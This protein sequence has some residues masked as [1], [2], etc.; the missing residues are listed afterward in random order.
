MNRFPLLWL[1]CLFVRLKY[2]YT[3]DPTDCETAGWK[4]HPHAECLQV[5]ANVTCVCL[6]GYQGNGQE[7]EDIDE[8]LSGLSDCHPNAL[9]NNTLGSYSCACRPGY[10]GNGFLCQ[11][12]NECQRENGRCHSNATCINYEGGSGCKCKTGFSGNGFQCTDNDEC[13]YQR[14]C[15]WNATCT[16][17]PG[18]Y[19]CTCNAGYKGNGNY[20][21]LDIDECSQTPVVCSSSLGYRGCKNLPGTYQCSCSTGYQN[22]GNYCQDIDECAAKRCSQYADCRNTLGSYRCTC[23]LGFEGNGLSCVDVNECNGN[24]NCHSSAVCINVVGRYECSC[25]PGFLGDGQNCQDV[26][27]CI[28]VGIC[29]TGAVCVNN[30]GSYDCNCGRGY[31]YNNSMCQDEDECASGLCSPYASCTNFP[32]SFNC[33]CKPGFNG[34]GLSCVDEDECSMARQCHANA[35]CINRPGSYNCSCE[36]GYSG[37]GVLRCTD[38]NECLV[39]NGGCRNLATCVNAQGSFSCLCSNGFTLVNKTLCQDV[40]ECEENSVACSANE[41]CLNTAGSYECRCLAGFYRPGGQVGCADVD[42]CRNKPCHANATCLNAEGSYECTCNG[43]FSGN[44]THCKDVNECLAEGRCH[45]RALC[46]N[47]EG[48]FSCVCQQGFVGDGFYCEDVNECL[49]NATCPPISTCINSPGAYVCSCLN[50]SVAIDSLCLLPSFQCDPACHPHGLCHSSPSGYQCVCDLGYMGDGLTCSDI[51]ECQL[52]NV[53]PRNETECVNIP[54]SFAC[55][56][57][58]GF[59]LNETNCVDVNECESP[60]RRCSE[61]SSCENTIGSHLCRCLSG[62]AGDGI[63]CLD[64]D[65]CQGDSGG[66]HPAASCANTPGSFRCTCQPGTEGSGFECRDVD[67]CSQNATLPHNCS[68]HGVCGNTDGSYRCWC[69]DGYH[70]DGFDC[71]DTDECRSGVSVCDSNMKCHNTLGSYTCTCVLGLAYEQGTCVSLNECQNASRSCHVN[72]RC[73]A[74]HSSFY[75]RCREGYFGDGTNCWDVDECDEGLAESPWDACPPSSSCINSNGS[76][77]CECWDGFRRAGKLCQDMD[78]CASGNFSCPYKST[79]HNVDGGYH[80]PCVP[81]FSLVNDSLCLDVDECSLGLDDC[82]HVSDC[83][84]TVGSFF[85]D[86]WPGYHGNGTVAWCMDI[87]EC[88]GNSTC[89]EHSTCNNTDGDFLCTCDSGFS[90]IDHLCVDVDECNTT[91]QAQPCANGVCMNTLGSYYCEC[92]KGYWSNETE[93]VDVDECSDLLDPSIDC[94]PF[95]TCVN[96]PGSYV[97]LCDEGFTLILTNSTSWIRTNE[98]IL[99]NLT[100]STKGSTL[101]SETHWTPRT[102]CQD[103]NECAGDPCP[104]YATC[105]NVEGSFL[106]LCDEGFLPDSLSYLS[107]NSSDNGSTMFMLHGCEDIDECVNH[108]ACRPDQACANLPGGYVCSCRVGYRE[109]KGACVDADECGS[110]HPC[111]P[112]ARCWNTEGSFSCHCLPGHRGN[113]TWCE[114]VDEC[115]ALSRPCHPMARCRN[116]LGSFWCQCEPGFAAL[117]TLCIDLD[118][119]LQTNGPCQP[120]ATCSNLVGGFDCQCKRGWDPTADMVNGRR[121]CLDQDEC[122]RPAACSGT[123]LCTNLPGSFRCSCP[124][125]DTECGHMALEESELFPF[126]SEVGDDHVEVSSED[127]NS[128]FITPPLGLPF[129]GKLYNRVFFSDNGLVQFQSV[130]QNEQ[131]LLPVPFPAGFR[132]NEGLAL[133]AVFW[134]DADL[135]LGQGRLLYKEYSS[136]DMSDIYSQIVFNRTAR[137]VTE[138][139]GQRGRPSFTPAWILKITWDSVMAISY[140]KVNLSETNTFQ[141]IL[142]T[143]GVRTFALLHYGAM[144]WGPGQRI[145][146]DALIGYTDGGTHYHNHNR[147]ASAADPTSSINPTAIA[148]SITATTGPPP[149][150]PYEPGGRYRPQHTVGPRGRPGQLLWDLSGPDPQ[151]EEAGEGA[152]VDQ[153]LRC[154]TWAQSEPAP[155]EWASEVPACPCTRAQ[156]TEDLAFLPQTVRPR[157]P[158]VRAL[159]DERWGGG[160]GHV[161]LSALPNRWGSGKTC[162]YDP[163]GELQGG[164]SERYFSADDTQRHIDEDLL[165][166]QWCCV[167]SPL[168]HLYLTKRPLDRCQG[169]GWVSPEQSTLAKKSTQG[170]AMVYGSLH[171][172]TFDGL[173]YSFRALGVFVLLR[174]SS[175]LGSNRFTLQG[176]M[177][178]LQQSGGRPAEAPVLVRMAAYHQGIGKVEWKCANQGD[179]LE[180]LVGGVSVPVTIGV[181]HRSAWGFIVRCVS[182]SRCAAVYAGGLHARAWR[183]GGGGGGGC[184]LGAVVEVPQAYYNRTVGLLGL[185]SS[186]RADD[187][188][189]SNGRVLPQASPDPRPED[190]LHTFGMSWEVPIPET[191]LSSVLLPLVPLHGPSPQ[192]LL[193]AVSPGDLAQLQRVCHGSPECVHDTLA[194]GSPALG[195]QS[196]EAQARYRYL[197]ALFGNMPPIVVEPMVIRGKVDSRMGVQLRAIDANRDPI[198]FSLLS[199]R[200]RMPSINSS[201]Y[202]TWLPQGAEPVELSVKVSDPLIS[203]LFSPVLQVCNCLNGGTCQYDAITTNYLQGKFQV[204]GCLC[205]EG[206]SGEFCRVVWD[207][208]LGDP[209]FPGVDCL[210]GAEPESFSCGECPSPNVYQGKQ[211][212]KC[213]QKDF[214]LPP[215]PFPCHEMADCD[216]NGYSYSCK[217]KPG[218]TGDG[219]NCTDIDECQDPSACPNAKF[220]CMNRPGSV[221]CS[222]RYQKS[223]VANGCG[224]SANPPGFNVFNVSMDWKDPAQDMLT[225]LE[226][227]LSVGFQNKFYNASIKGPRQGSGP[228]AG[229]YRI[230]VS[231]DTPAWYIQEYLGRVGRFYGIGL[232]EVGDLDECTAKE[233]ACV[234]PALCANTYGGYRCVCNGT[235]E[236]DESQ[237][238]VLGSGVIQAGNQSI[239]VKPLEGDNT[240]LILGLVLGIGIP[241]L[242]LL[243]ALL[244]FYCCC[245]RKKTAPREPSHL[246]PGYLQYI[247]PPFNYSDPSLQYISHSCPRSLDTPPPRSY[248]HTNHIYSSAS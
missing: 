217:C 10:I 146:Q 48:G 149:A 90:A 104:Q 9:C 174:L 27:E 214:C 74:D 133:L 45:Q 194:T 20:L 165:P 46:I 235:T 195:L 109:E 128:P 145:H 185:W 148:V 22:N 178:R 92:T 40:D 32:A 233:A 14:I 115:V 99:I 135:T 220:E 222:C 246:L 154:Q 179:G 5:N 49:F 86:C 124:S 209:C 132:G 96:A 3:A 223:M 30:P 137:A 241:F 224:E 219:F 50:G 26:D 191:L 54:G 234:W 227:I 218:Y 84:N 226:E 72:A 147:P 231:S 41:W 76:Y 108:S 189:M 138:F 103:I 243:L 60:V 117:G 8:C 77:V 56:C 118:E 163:Q 18:S 61:F 196:L 213:F 208:C 172:I 232:P 36:V 31:L 64:V 101:T 59:I 212:Y 211:G 67:E 23:T 158:Q 181:V 57:R 134:D 33:Q 91:E 204:V 2:C 236:V 65:E 167:E 4:C 143:D 29:P 114:D 175:A 85:C 206:F 244:C 87:D 162:V 215:S 7:C 43:G 107:S 44:G 12:I 150:G 238:C 15:H 242:L 202:L 245:P 141:C 225:Q 13:S 21:C 119:C 140:Q 37:D 180:L 164:Y 156:A 198:T 200:P 69:Q 166:F 173:R 81:G 122:T 186:T 169:Y 102:E 192:E 151:E 100:P 38:V 248:H 176:E 6:N 216:N 68:V 240:A 94:Q 73:Y 111:H 58:A 171:F 229:E 79:C 131:R 1:I 127:G 66:C 144:R 197:T 55:I 247:P 170:V 125:N 11:D 112:W 126:G 142:T 110:A 93:C 105:Q 159:R 24:H 75:C 62:F 130:S 16:N 51:D 53:C 70:G 17:N 82:P 120:G 187:L 97:C 157:L 207:P 52:E 63:T 121:G 183:V 239:V 28:T 35:V 182:L 152:E 98:T 193:A 80:C 113:G 153:R 201:G 25:L 160:S 184:Q 19:V 78:E 34:D 116:T 221:H 161:F 190:H 136:L 71:V 88:L 203:S 210:P 123:A 199:P 230:N 39:D 188:L 168:C 139:E 177:G 89:P 155:D 47:A 129:M 83:F 42:E 205:P 228:G 106:C 237:A 95:A